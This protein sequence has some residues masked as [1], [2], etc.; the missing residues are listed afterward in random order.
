MA[1]VSKTPYVT[2]GGAIT[3]P[4]GTFFNAANQYSLISV[5]VAGNIA[6]TGTGSIACTAGQQ[7]YVP[8][9]VGAVNGSAQFLYT[10][11]QNL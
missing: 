7:I 10:T 8:P 4:A 1:T 2:G 11:F 5:L 9:N 3:A 6:F